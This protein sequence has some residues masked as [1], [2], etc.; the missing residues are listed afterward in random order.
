MNQFSADIAGVLEIAI[1]AAGLVTL[2]F[3]NK[4]KAPL[5]R[6]AAWLMIIGGIA[7][8]MCT[9]Y[10]WL[11]YHRQGDFDTVMVHERFAPVDDNGPLHHYHPDEWNGPTDGNKK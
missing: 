11:K 9:A 4:E 5:L 2:Y 6:A 8:G 1:I 7:V 10:W 3:A